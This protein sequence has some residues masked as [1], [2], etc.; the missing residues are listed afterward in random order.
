MC[1]LLIAG[2]YLE[3]GKY[4]KAIIFTG[5]H[6]NSA[7]K[8]LII[9]AGLGAAFYEINKMS[10]AIDYYNIAI[11]LNPHK[12]EYFANCPTF[13]LKKAD[14]ASAIEYYKKALELD[15]TDL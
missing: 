1:I 3:K 7:L 12:Q 13:I 6:W 15:D 14:N 2:A 4:E 11:K 10:E 5:R 8:I 9:Y